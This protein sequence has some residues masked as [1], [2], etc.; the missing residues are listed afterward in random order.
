M[1]KSMRNIQWNSANFLFNELCL[2]DV[3]RIER[4]SYLNKNPIYLVGSK[5]K[6]D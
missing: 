2:C 4:I 6:A 1:T 5:Y 3:I